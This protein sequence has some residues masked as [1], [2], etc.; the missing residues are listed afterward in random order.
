VILRPVSG[1]SGDATTHQLVSVDS[2]NAVIETV[3]QAEDGE[4]LIVRLYEGERNRGPVTLKVGFPVM[5]AYH[6]NL[7]EENQN[8]LTV[9][10]DQI[11]LTLRPYEIATL[12]I[13]AK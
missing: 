3:K 11:T 12:R 4:G 9:E 1:A 6:C 13:V 5:A 8:E 7:L 10:N 2:R